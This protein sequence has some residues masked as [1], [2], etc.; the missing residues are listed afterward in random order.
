MSWEV[1]LQYI[2][3]HIP[4]IVSYA[5][6]LLAYALY[7]IVKMKASKIGKGMT[8]LVKEKTEKVDKQE[9]ALRQLVLEQSAL[10]AKQ[11]EEL[12]DMMQK[13]NERM[14]R[15]EEIVCAIADVS[16]QEIITEEVVE[17]GPDDS[18]DEQ[19]VRDGQSIEETADGQ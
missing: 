10:I 5:L 18:N 6:T 16:A 11:A 14:Q 8:L 1:V 9:E 2:Q 15:N 4:I 13:L 3:E 19:V 17:N 7:F 12:R